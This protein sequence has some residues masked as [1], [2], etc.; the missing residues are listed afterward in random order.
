MK[1]TIIFR[2]HR[3]K[4][5]K[6]HA[7]P[8]RRPQENDSFHEAPFRGGNRNKRP[9]RRPVGNTNRQPHKQRKKYPYYGRKKRS[10]E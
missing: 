5:F 4:V 1:I 6:K 9:R 10:P 8:G 7:R 2:N 3:K